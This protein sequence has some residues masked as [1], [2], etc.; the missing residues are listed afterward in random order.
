ME[1]RG[2]APEYGLFAANPPEVDVE[3]SPPSNE[4][5]P[6]VFGQGMS[7]GPMSSRLNSVASTGV[8]IVWE[9][10]MEEDTEERLPK[11]EV[12][13]MSGIRLLLAGTATMPLPANP[14]IPAMVPVCRMGASCS[15][16][17]GR[18]VDDTGSVIP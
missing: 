12:A 10:V 7:S 11:S 2:L 17:V 4:S 13:P 6:A 15:I 3:M 18:F 1:S 16:D 14:M 8:V 5:V 9:E